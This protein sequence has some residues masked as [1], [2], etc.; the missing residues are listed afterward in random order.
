MN[1]DRREAAN[2]ARAVQG[3]LTNLRNELLSEKHGHIKK[4]REIPEEKLLPTF[5][6]L[7]GTMADLAELFPGRG[8]RTTI[9]EFFS[10]VGKSLID[11]QRSLDAGSQS[12]LEAAR[13]SEHILP[14][15]FRIPK[16]SAE[17][18]FKLEKRGTK[19][20]HLVFL[21]QKQEATSLHQQSLQFEIAATPPP[22]E[23]VQALRSKAPRL[24]LVLSP[25]ERARVFDAIRGLA[26]PA[27]L[28][29]DLLLQ[30]ANE[31][32]IAAVEPDKSYLLLY[33]NK[34]ELKHIGVWHVQLQPPKLE[35]AYKYN[36]AHNK[37][38]KPERF[39]KF[40]LD[41]AARQ[42]AFLRKMG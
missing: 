36:V 31:V 18:R 8:E 10:S 6:E 1:V 34:D 23:V 33:A 13:A 7:A 42:A 9:A 16:V 40:V 29:K 24:E 25:A 14:S 39:K 38:H 12:Y 2:A 22:P 28:H 15:V 37:A 4:I 20:H 21:S 17:V 27:D 3:A 35:A 41:L 30:H 26:V 11:A 32:L 19:G 5:E